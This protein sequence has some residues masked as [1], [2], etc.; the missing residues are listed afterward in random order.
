MSILI[1]DDH[2]LN[3]QLLKVLLDRMGYRSTE[4]RDGIEALE[5]YEQ[6]YD[7]ELAIVDLMMPRLDGW[8]LIAAIREDPH[9]YG[10]PIV[11]CTALAD[12]DT[13]TRALQFGIRHF[14]VK[15]ITKERVAAQLQAAFATIPPRLAPAAGVRASL[16]ASLD[17]YYQHIWNFAEEVQRRRDDFAYGFPTK[18]D[19]EP[20]LQSCVVLGAERTHALAAKALGA[21]GRREAEAAWQLFRRDLAQLSHALSRRIGE[22]ET[23][24]VQASGGD[25][26]APR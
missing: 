2:D 12:R 8:G 19:L 22:L 1:V 7:V 18:D 26:P 15:P 9:W 24:M 6:D 11:L 25:T 20:L 10:I 4:A 23:E 3:R 13:V 5:V 21:V 14:L 17:D 16:G